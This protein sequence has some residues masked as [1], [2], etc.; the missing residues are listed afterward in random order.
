MVGYV[1]G[2]QG[3]RINEIRQ[4]SQATVKIVEV[5]EGSMDRKIVISGSPYNVSSA[6]HLITNILARYKA[7][8]KE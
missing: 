5:E 3:S 8:A 7:P 4:N 1:I 2:R 6:T